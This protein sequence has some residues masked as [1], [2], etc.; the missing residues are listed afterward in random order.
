MSRKLEIAKLDTAELE[1]LLPVLKEALQLLKDIGGAL[2]NKSFFDALYL[3]GYNMEP[4]TYA[5]IGPDIEAV[6]AAAYD[7]GYRLPGEQ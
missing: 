5:E 6:L 7:L 1:P 2:D 4:Y 3:Q